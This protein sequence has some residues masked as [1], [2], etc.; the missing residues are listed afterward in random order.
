MVSETAW[1]TVAF[2]LFFLISR[3]YVL[4]KNSAYRNSSLFDV[5]IDTSVMEFDSTGT[6][7]T[8]RR[9]KNIPTAYLSPEKIFGREG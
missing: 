9:T 7:V 4:V 2:L 3:L 5:S 6:T 8:N 1:K